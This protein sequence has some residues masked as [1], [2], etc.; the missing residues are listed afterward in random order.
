MIDLVTS[1]TSSISEFINDP[2]KK[3]KLNS[4]R[5]ALLKER[6]S[7][8]NKFKKFKRCE[9]DLRDRIIEFEEVFNI[10][11]ELKS[12]YDLEKKEHV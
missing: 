7:F 2:N 5:L 10:L 9:N 6:E 8:K 1:L 12:S 11:T 4:D 3:D